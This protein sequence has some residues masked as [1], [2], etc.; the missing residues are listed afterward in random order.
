MIGPHYFIPSIQYMDLFPLGF[1]SKY[2]QLPGNHNR[3]VSHLC[4]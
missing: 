3:K 2:E 4:N 1:L